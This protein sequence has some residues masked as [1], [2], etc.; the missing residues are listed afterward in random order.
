VTNREHQAARRAAARARGD[1][2]T[3]CKRPA[4]PGRFRCVECDSHRVATGAERAAAWYQRQREAGLCKRC[5]IATGGWT[6]CFG[7][8]QVMRVEAR[9]R[10]H[11]LRKAGLCTACK[12]DANGRA[13][14][15][16][17]A[18]KKSQRG[19]EARP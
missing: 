4:Q 14:C 1:C 3:C 6:H 12:A 9:D 19:L 16:P 5:G 11:D 8:A 2:G 15:R 13:L 17:C 7:C 10:Y 18:V